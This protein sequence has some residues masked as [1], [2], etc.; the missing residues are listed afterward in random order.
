MQ[1]TL[2][3][4]RF[5]DDF[6][7]IFLPGLL[8][9]EVDWIIE[10]FER[11]F[12]DSGIEHDGTQRSSIGPFI[13]RSERLCTLLDHPKVDGLLCGLM[14][15]DYNYLGSG[16]ELYVGDGMWHPDNPDKR[17]LKV[18][19]AMYLDPVIKDTGALRVVPGS[20]KQEWV[21]NLDT[22]D[23]WGLTPDEVPCTTPVNQPGDVMV[24][25]QSTLH[26]SVKG[27]NRRRMLNMVACAH[28]D[29]DEELQILRRSLP[30]TR[31]DL[32]WDLMLDT[33]T[34]VR[35]RHLKQP[36]EILP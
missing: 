11:V 17:V 32:H 15:D 20:H 31:E 35:M 2:Q 33:A 4:K 25:H 22:E 6:G 8:A 21:G 1:L 5:F 27:G 16:G 12:H 34:P 10:E 29:T 30:K 24:F 23:L 18:K 13:E 7:Y 28:C 19:W 36:L 14:D 26:N 9:D 3:Q